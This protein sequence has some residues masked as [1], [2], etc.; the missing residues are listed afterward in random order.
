MLLGGFAGSW[1]AAGGDWALWR[2]VTPGNTRTGDIAVP[3]ALGATS[4][5][6]YTTMCAR[7]GGELAG[8]EAVIV[9]RWRLGGC[10]R[11]EPRLSR[12]LTGYVSLEMQVR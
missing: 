11:G 8:I 2:H 9:L 1:F 4:E 10:P 3:M 12:R 5:E 7:R 6:M